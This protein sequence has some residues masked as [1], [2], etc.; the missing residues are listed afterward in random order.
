MESFPVGRR[1]A[2][3]P[4]RGRLWVVCH[5][6]ERW[7]LTPLEERWEAV[8]EGERLFRSTRLRVSTDEIGLACHP[9]GLELVRIG[10]PLRPEFAAWRYGDQFGSRRRRFI[11]NSLVGAGVAGGLMLGSG[12]VVGGAVALQ[13]GV[14][15]FNV[16]RFL[17]STVQPG[18]RI[19]RDDGR[20]LTLRTQDLRT[21]RLRPGGDEASWHL[22]LDHE[23]GSAQLEGR[24]AVRALRILLPRV[25]GKGGSPKAVKSA[26][27]ELEE[28]GGPDAYFAQAEYRARRQGMGYMTLPAL[29]RPIRLALEMAAHEDVEREAMEGELAWLTSAWRKAEELAAI[30][31]DLTLPERVLVRFREMKARRGGSVADPNGGGGEGADL[32][33]P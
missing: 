22:A 27:R 11:R 14:H 28:V 6:C 19:H 17:R 32:A 7:N 10:D 16:V 33:A 25:N 20:A 8:E 24:E 15:T 29:P 1:L 23:G 26:V 21:P 31:D 12:I 9:E 2:F 5:S 18:I 3:D 13:L 4:G 30:A